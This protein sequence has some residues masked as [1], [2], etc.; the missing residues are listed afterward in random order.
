MYMPST[1]R[2]DRLDPFAGNPED[3]LSFHK[4]GFVHGD[5]IQGV[6]P[7]GLQFSLSGMVMTGAIIGGVGGL[8]GGTTFGAYKTGKLFS[9]ETLKYSLAGAALGAAAGAAAG[10]SLY[11]LIVGG[12]GL[13]SAVFR[14]GMQSLWQKA[15][16]PHWR[17]ANAAMYGFALGLVAGM[18]DPSYEVAGMLNGTAAFGVLDNILVRGAFAN[19]ARLAAILGAAEGRASLAL[20]GPLRTVGQSVAFVGTGFAI[21]VAA[22]Y[23]TGSG[24]RYLLDEL[25]ITPQTNWE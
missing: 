4:Y 2:F 17:T 14:Q 11:F 18:V 15:L 10:G 16:T 5:P 1:G 25:E 21:G 7:S 13:T 8:V 12:P 24:L 9:I 6:D 3:P 23:L 20:L 19:R 22:G